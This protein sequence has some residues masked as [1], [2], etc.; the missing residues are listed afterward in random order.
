M[1]KTEFHFIWIASTKNLFLQEA[2]EEN[3]TFESFLESVSALLK[4]LEE[5]VPEGNK[6]VSYQEVILPSPE[7]LLVQYA[8]RTIF[9][10]ADACDERLTTRYWLA[11]P[12]DEADTDLENVSRRE[13]NSFLGKFIFGKE[14]LFVSNHCFFF[15]NLVF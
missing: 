3:K 15:G 8:H 6:K 2:V 1:F 12:A 5:D 13:N 7:T 9:S 14:N 10:S 11:T 4:V